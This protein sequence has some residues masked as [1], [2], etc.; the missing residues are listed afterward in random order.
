VAGLVAREME[1]S[2]TGA[3]TGTGHWRLLEQDGV[4]AV[5]YDCS[6]AIC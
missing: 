5:L 3:L 6:V 2:A 4:T 1:G